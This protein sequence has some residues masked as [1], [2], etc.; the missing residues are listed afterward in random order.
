MPIGSVIVSVGGQEVL[1]KAK[2]I[3]A[4]RAEQKRHK[5]ATGSGAG[6]HPLSAVTTARYTRLTPSC[7]TPYI[8]SCTCANLLSSEHQIDPI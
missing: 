7:C 4:I 2:V 5:D 3:E 6:T 8:I 1:G